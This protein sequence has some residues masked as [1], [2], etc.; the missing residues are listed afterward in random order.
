MQPANF[1]APHYA[2]VVPSRFVTGLK[3]T[4]VAN[5]G[6]K[7]GFINI[8]EAFHNHDDEVKYYYNSKQDFI[9]DKDAKTAYWPSLNT[10]KGNKNENVWSISDDIKKDIWK[11]WI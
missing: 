9:C 6:S 10:I 2:T 1:G 4:I 11:Q 5:V 8:K 7:C 3:G